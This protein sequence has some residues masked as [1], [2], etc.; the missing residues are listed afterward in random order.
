MHLQFG[1]MKRWAIIGSGLSRTNSDRNHLMERWQFGQLGTSKCPNASFSR[2][3]VA[4][5]VEGNRISSHP[6]T[7]Y[8]MIA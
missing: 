6:I 7:S 4:P 2:F 5:Q 1:Q 8:Q 3:M